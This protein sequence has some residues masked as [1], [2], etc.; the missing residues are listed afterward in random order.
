MLSSNKQTLL[1]KGIC[2][3]EDLKSA[4]VVGLHQLGMTELLADGPD[5]HLWSWTCVC[6]SLFSTVDEWIGS[7]LPELHGFNSCGWGAEEDA[8]GFAKN[9]SRYTMCVPNAWRPIFAARHSY[10]TAWRSSRNWMRWEKHWLTGN[11]GISTAYRFSILK[12]SWIIHTIYFIFQFLYLTRKFEN[13]VLV[14]D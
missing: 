11:V 12:I 4:V 7:S 5:W 10:R 6:F 8:T 14:L 13:S 3:N 2:R 9:V 1:V